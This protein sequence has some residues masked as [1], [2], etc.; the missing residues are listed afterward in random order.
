[1]QESAK[2]FLSKVARSEAYSQAGMGTG[3]PHDS[4]T[5]VADVIGFAVAVCV[6]LAKSASIVYLVMKVDD[7]DGLN[8]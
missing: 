4:D 8:L 1:M 5:L 7:A 2:N 6:P 3:T